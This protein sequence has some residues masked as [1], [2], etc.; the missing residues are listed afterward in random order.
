MLRILQP[1]LHCFA[2]AVLESP[3]IG[4]QAL[5][6]RVR[7]GGAEQSSPG[8]PQIYISVEIRENPQLI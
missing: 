1:G 5:K 3:A 4:T 8:L 7:A 6:A 2:P